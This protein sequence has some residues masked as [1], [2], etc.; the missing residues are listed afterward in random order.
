MKSLVKFCLPMKGRRLGN[1]AQ[2]STP[3]LLNSRET[4]M[5]VERQG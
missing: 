5:G 2:D 1:M 4:A 3:G